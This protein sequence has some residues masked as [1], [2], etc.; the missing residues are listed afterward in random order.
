ME[1]S[2]QTDYA[3]RAIEYL[4]R[5]P[6]GD[7]VQTREIAI[8]QN[9]PEKYLPTIVR[10]LARAG[11]LKTMRGNHGGIRL[12]RPATEITLREVIEAV[13]G[14]LVI[15]RNALPTGSSALND[16]DSID[17]LREFWGKINADVYE[18]LDRV[19]IGDLVDG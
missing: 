2:R 15:N 18:E 16:G 13:D 5:V 9:I 3:I 19:S 10:T 17:V 11:L 6:D 4:A 7:L 8:K 12:S 14:P 1:I